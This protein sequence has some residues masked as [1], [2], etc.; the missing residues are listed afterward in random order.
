MHL[1]MNLLFKCLYVLQ[2]EM[3]KGNRNIN[4]LQDIFKFIYKI[5]NLVLGLKQKTLES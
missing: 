4:W 1:F 2:S 5:S 3:W